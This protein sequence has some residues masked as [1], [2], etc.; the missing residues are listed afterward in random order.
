MAVMKIEACPP[1]TSARTPI[2]TGPAKL[3]MLP[4]CLSRDI[5]CP[6]RACGVTSALK[7]P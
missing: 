7:A 5:A 6:R 2:V 1:M 3:M 4:A